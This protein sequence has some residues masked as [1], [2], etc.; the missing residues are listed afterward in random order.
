M[1]SPELPRP[2]ENPFDPPQQPVQYS[3]P[4]D[5]DD[6]VRRRRRR[7][8][9]VVL[10]IVLVPIATLIGAGFGCT[11]GLLVVAEVRDSNLLV[12]GILS[13]VGLGALLGAGLTIFLLV[14]IGKRP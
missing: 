10:G 11:A 6:P 13:L 9:L 4:L 12:S 3:A 14:L 2:D 8:L 5:A 1:S 7:I